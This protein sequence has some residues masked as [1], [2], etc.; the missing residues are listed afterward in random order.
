[1]HEEGVIGQKDAPLLQGN[2]GAPL[3]ADPARHMY[4]VPGVL[5]MFA[6][7]REQIVSLHASGGSLQVGIGDGVVVAEEDDDVAVVVAAVV[8]VVT[9]VV[10][11]SFCMVNTSVRGIAIDAIKINANATLIIVIVTFDIFVQ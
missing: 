6:V 1:M 2:G 9:V 10:G 8:V 3:A 7:G 11:V 4:C 5:Q